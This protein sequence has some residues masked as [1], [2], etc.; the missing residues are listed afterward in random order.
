MARAKVAVSTN[1]VRMFLILI[2]LLKRLNPGSDNGQPQGLPLQV[3][4]K[5]FNSVNS[6]SDIL[7]P[8]RL[9]GVMM[10]AVVLDGVFGYYGV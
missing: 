10:V 3:F 2:L 5:F 9:F 7:R 1:L 6:G 4:C 8:L